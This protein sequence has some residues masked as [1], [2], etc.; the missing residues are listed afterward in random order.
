[1]RVCVK[2][3]DTKWYSKI[4]NVNT[5]CHGS[6]RGPLVGRTN[7]VLLL[8]LLLATSSSSVH[9]RH[10]FTARFQTFP[11]VCFLI[12]PCCKYVALAQSTI[13]RGGGY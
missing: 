4:Q 6:R 11:Q 12:N 2:L 5:Q 10:R 9:G 7:Y 3:Y 8:L 13:Q 1:M